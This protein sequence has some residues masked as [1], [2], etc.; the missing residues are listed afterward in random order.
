MDAALRRKLQP[1]Q[2]Q[3]LPPAVPCAETSRV[4]PVLGKAGAPVKRDGAGVRADHIQLDLC[5]A[6]LFRALDTGVCQRTADPLSPL[7]PVY[8]DPE[9]SAVLYFI[10]CSH[11]LD[12][13]RSRQLSVDKRAE[14]HRAVALFLLNEKLTLL[15][16]IKAVF[17]RIHTLLFLSGGR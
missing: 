2:H 9:I 12:T 17:I 10:L 4:S 8:A 5:I 14:L 16:K 11:R 7:R 1:H 15:S 13:G 6:R 3:L